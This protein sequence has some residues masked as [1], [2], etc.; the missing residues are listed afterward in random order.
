[1]FAGKAMQSRL[2]VSRQ[3][4]N[5]NWW[6]AGG[7]YSLFCD[8]VHS[9][10]ASDCSCTTNL[11]YRPNDAHTSAT[12][13]SSST[14]LIESLESP[15]NTFWS[16]ERRIS[17]STCSLVRPAMMFSNNSR[18]LMLSGTWMTVHVTIQ[19]LW[20]STVRF[21]NGMAYGCTCHVINMGGDCY[22]INN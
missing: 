14:T 15:T 18:K 17:S 12:S 21:A 22:L 1:M 19:R 2:S 7:H 8:C 3:H 6:R 11:M 5:G 20:V 4:Q 13:S 16:E 9:V 10:S